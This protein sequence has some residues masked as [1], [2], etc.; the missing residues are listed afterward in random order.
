MHS[1]PVSDIKSHTHSIGDNNIK[2]TIHV[3]GDL[4]DEYDDATGA[5][6]PLK[7]HAI[8]ESED[9][10]IDI[11]INPEILV[12]KLT[13]WLAE[14]MEILKNI[15]KINEKKEQS[16]SENTGKMQHL[17]DKAGSDKLD[18]ETE[19]ESEANQTVPKAV[20]KSGAKTSEVAK[21]I[22][23]QEE[24]RS[25]NKNEAVNPLEKEITA[26][27]VEGDSH[28]LE[29]KP[30]QYSKPAIAVEILGKRYDE[31]D[32]E[33]D[34]AEDEEDL[35]DTEYENEDED[36]YP[37]VIRISYEDSGSVEEEEEDDDDYD[38][39]DE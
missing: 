14:K 35:G 13:N 33:E 28:A 21:K 32:V 24:V 29:A 25:D 30:L 22:T 34:D 9:I 31:D 26:E 23:E 2:V 17:D 37:E 3:N 20:P 8:E 4:G 11:S 5:S 1:A 16:I 15:F 10:K 12:D 7:N 6:S 18:D 39:E 27:K 19:D 36:N 38:F